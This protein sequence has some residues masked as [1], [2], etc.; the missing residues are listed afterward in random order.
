MDRWDV[1]SMGGAGVKFKAIAAAAELGIPCA[2]I[3]DYD[4]MAGKGEN[5]FNEVSWDT[6]MR[7]DII[8]VN[9]SLALKIDKIFEEH[10]QSMEAGQNEET[11]DDTDEKMCRE[12]METIGPG[13]SELLKRCKAL[14]G[15]ELDKADLSVGSSS[16]AL[17]N[18]VCNALEEHNMLFWR[19]GSLEKALFKDNGMVKVEFDLNST[20]QQA[21]NEYL[22]N[23]QC[24]E[25]Y[26]PDM[27]RDGREEFWDKLYQFF[28]KKKRWQI[29]PWSAL[30]GLVEAMWSVEDSNI[31]RLWKFMLKVQKVTS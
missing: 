2:V 1:I 8:R 3:V 21:L 16:K 27:E 26:E 19:N 10:S 30:I 13:A 25:L 12:F 7:K 4:Q 9:K 18:N 20:N 23:H 5:A 29:I 11:V 14:I 28:K 17:L 24:A 31:R 22:M 6:Q 15:E